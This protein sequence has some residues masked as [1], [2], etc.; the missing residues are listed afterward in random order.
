[1]LE[2]HLQSLQNTFLTPAQSW[3]RQL[4]D[5]AALHLWKDS[6]LAGDIWNGRWST[7]T[8]HE[9][10]GEHGSS[11]IPEKE[12]AISCVSAHLACYVLPLI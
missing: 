6:E 2:E 11:L 10:L 3:I 8:T 12:D 4:I 9:V 5:Y 7:H 1:M